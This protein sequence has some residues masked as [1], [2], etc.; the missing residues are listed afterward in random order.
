MHKNA[1]NVKRKTQTKICCHYTWLLHG[2][3]KGKE[4]PTEIPKIEKPKDI[5]HFLLQK[6][7]QNFDFC[8]CPSQN[9]TKPDASGK[10][11]KLS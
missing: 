11:A 5:G 4:R 9:V 8:A 1:Q 6:L 2:K 3:R 7:S 10:K